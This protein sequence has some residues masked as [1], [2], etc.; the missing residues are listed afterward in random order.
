[1]R[2]E[3]KN[4]ALYCLKKIQKNEFNKGGTY[5]FIMLDGPASS[6]LISKNNSS[7]IQ[8]L[9]ICKHNHTS[10]AICV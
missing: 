2:G 6:G 1:M 3:T 7:I 5:L 8:L 9:K 10:Y 4:I